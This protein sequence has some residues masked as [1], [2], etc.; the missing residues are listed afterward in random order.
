MGAM[1]DR[2]LEFPIPSVPELHDFLVE[3]PIPRRLAWP[4][5]KLLWTHAAAICGGLLLASVIY[6]LVRWDGHSFDQPGGTSESIPVR[7]GQA[8]T[9]GVFF[10]NEHD[11]PVVVERAT[12]ANTPQGVRLL[13]MSRQP[14]IGAV[15]GWSGSSEIRGLVVPAHKTAFIDVGLRADRPGNY[16]IGGLRI[17]YRGGL[18]LPLLGRGHYVQTTGTTIRLRVSGP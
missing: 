7:V 9:V 17:W 3:A 15:L 5:R 12:L 10:H 2:V 4:W 1:R 11:S 18:D 6:S 13:G 16:F 14:A 8:V